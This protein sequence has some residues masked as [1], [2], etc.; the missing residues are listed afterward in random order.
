MDISIEGHLVKRGIELGTFLSREQCL[1]YSTTTPQN[2]SYVDLV[3][4]QVTV[5]LFMNLCLYL[6]N[7]LSRILFAYS[8]ICYVFNILI[9]ID[10]NFNI[11]I[12]Y[13]W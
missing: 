2:V 12:I 9:D 1:N 8:V 10:F 3:M 11:Q 5:K 4:V 13:K 7:Y 6:C